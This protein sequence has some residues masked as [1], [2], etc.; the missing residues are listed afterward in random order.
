MTGLRGIIERSHRQVANLGVY[1]MASLVPMVLSL[2][3]NPLLASNLSPED[4]SIIGYYSAFTVLFTPFVTFYLLN[5]YTKRYYE[6]TPD[7]RNILR[8]TLVRA[9][10]TMSFL[11]AALSLMFLY[12]YMSFFN[13]ESEIRFLPY[14]LLANVSIPL[15]GVYSLA[16][17]DYRMRRDS[18][19]FFRL[20]VCNG[21][22]GVALALLLVVVFRLGAFG[23]LSA[24]SLAALLVF[25]F[26]MYRNR[27]VWRMP[28]GW[29]ILWKS[30]RFCSPLV[31]AAML[32]FFSNGYDKVMLERNGDLHSLG[33]YTVGF[34]IASYISVFSNSIND[35]FQPDIF[36]SVVSRDF[37]RCFRFVLLKLSLM[38]VLAA[39]FILVSP[40]VV[41]I[42]TAGRYMESL[43]YAN[44]IALSS[45]TSMM[46]YSMSQVTIA[47]GY[48]YVTLANKVLGSV[49]SIASF[50][51]LITRFGATGAAWGTVLSYLYFFLG[52]ALMVAI[53]HKCHRR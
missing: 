51:F 35:T 49:L 2:A 13:A 12:I 17:V 31:V 9:L 14:A 48:T 4:Y 53:V 52:N 46:Y 21:V 42:L 41:R 28:F 16:L 32:G 5:Y 24:T 8:G 29:D 39:L 26:L 50:Y 36:E 43:P 47:L 11:L 37:R 18:K 7:R 38:T 15:T 3:A 40:L 10:S 34:S 22:L 25:L 44:I 30:V 45:I 27:D 1:F 20:S 23:R 33:I 19:G 6:L